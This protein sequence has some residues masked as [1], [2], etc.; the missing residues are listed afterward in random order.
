MPKQFYTPAMAELRAAITEAE[1]LSAKGELTKRD[2]SRVNVLLAKIAALKANALAPDNYAERWFRS[3]LTG[4]EP[5]QRAD[6]IAG[7]QTPTYTQGVPGGYLTPQEFHNELVIGSALIDPLLDENVV[8]LVQS[9]AYR[10]RPYKVPG[11]DLTTFAAQK[12][13]EANQHNPQTPPAATGD[14]LNG[15]IYRATLDDSFEFEEDNFQPVINQINS[16]FQIGFARGIGVDLIT[17]D[18]T[19]GPQGALTG[20]ADS[21]VTSASATVLLGT[22]L[23]AIYFKVN[24]AY[25]YSKKCAWLMHDDIY[26]LVRKAKDLNDRPLINIVGDQ[27]LLMGKPIRLSPTMPTAAGSKAIL[28][29]DFSHYVVRVSRSIMQ[30]TMQAA[31]YAEKGKYLYSGLMRADAKVVDPTGGVKPPLVYAK[32]HT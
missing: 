24:P 12:V 6:L 1:A 7:K 32:L 9:N 29:G 22:E 2:E 28:F 18:G 5:E 23:E 19:T 15:W 4:E 20:A 30:R 31:G 8:T 11:W 14:Q 25:R 27:E 16:A 13:T 17:G 10:L 26:Q 3:F 21:G